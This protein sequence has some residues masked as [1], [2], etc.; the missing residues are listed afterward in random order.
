M[1]GSRSALSPAIIGSNIRHSSD[2]DRVPNVF[3]SANANWKMCIP[4]RPQHEDQIEAS[5]LK[6]IEILVSLDGRLPKWGELV[7]NNTT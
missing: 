1:S 3:Q 2:R 6:G 4:L 5:G 7:K